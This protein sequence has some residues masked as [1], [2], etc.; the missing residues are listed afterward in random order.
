MPPGPLLLALAQS[1]ADHAS[2]FSEGARGPDCTL[3][4]GFG[5]LVRQATL[6]ERIDAG[7]QGRLQL[8]A[9]FGAEPGDILALGA[10][11]EWTFTWTRDVVHQAVT[12]LVTEL[13]PVAVVLGAPRRARGPMR[14]SLARWLIGRPN[15][16]A[17]VVPA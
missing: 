15:V 16:Q 10:H 6:G 7:A 13:S 14:P 3:Q 1:G 11:V 2:K 12:R 8:P 17:V 5:P 4:P 9:V